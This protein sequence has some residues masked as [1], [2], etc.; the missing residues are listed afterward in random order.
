MVAKPILQVR[1][2]REFRASIEL[3]NTGYEPVRWNTN[4]YNYEMNEYGYKFD[5]SKPAHVNAFNG[6]FAKRWFSRD[7]TKLPA[8]IGDIGSIQNPE[9]LIFTKDKTTPITNT[10]TKFRAEFGIGSYNSYTYRKLEK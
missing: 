5:L 1:K 10:D 4:Q 8:T 6:I 3:M 7:I 2:G 9:Y